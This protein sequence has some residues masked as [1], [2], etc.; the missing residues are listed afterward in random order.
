MSDMVGRHHQHINYNGQIIM[1]I[2]FLVFQWKI[3]LI[4]SKFY[5]IIEEAL[6]IIL[7]LHQAS[8]K[9]YTILI[10]LLEYFLIL[11]CFAIMVIINFYVLWL[12]YSNHFVSIQQRIL[13]IFRTVQSFIK[14]Y[15]ATSFLHWSCKKRLWQKMWKWT[16]WRE[17]W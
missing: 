11:H 1:K 16:L 7:N 4:I 9:V 8:L 13:S 14:S 12:T 15:K 17:I 2:W 10:L 3:Y 5:V 6:S